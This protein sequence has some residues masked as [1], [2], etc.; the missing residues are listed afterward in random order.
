MA[1]EAVVVVET[2]AVCTTRAVVL[3]EA[4]VLVVARYMLH[5]CVSHG[6]VSYNSVFVLACFVISPEYSVARFIL[7]TIKIRNYF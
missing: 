5:T 3:G 7:Y 1:V 4:A 2:A 6:L